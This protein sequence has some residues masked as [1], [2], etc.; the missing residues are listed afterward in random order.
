MFARLPEKGMACSRPKAFG[1]EHKEIR[2]NKVR[3]L[4]PMPQVQIAKKAMKSMLPRLPKLDS[5]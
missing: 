5:P 2:K 4:T 1:I 3:Q